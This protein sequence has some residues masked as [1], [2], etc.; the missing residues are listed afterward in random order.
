MT[1][2]EVLNNGLQ[3]LGY[4]DSNGNAH[5]TQVIRNRALTIVNLVYMELSRNCGIEN[6]ALFSLS[7]DVKLPE[8]VLI[9]VMPCGVAMYVANAENDFNAEAFWSKEY[10]AKRTTLSRIEVVKDTLPNV[11]SE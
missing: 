5:L 11:W 1:G 7:D 3:L 2:T 4:S 8:R 9:E 10:N 6:T